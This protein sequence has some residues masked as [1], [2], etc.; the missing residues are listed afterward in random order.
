MAVNAG[1]WCFCECVTEL[2]K[3]FT[4]FINPNTFN[5]ITVDKNCGTYALT[6]PINNEI[7]STD[8]F[9]SSDYP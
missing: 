6:S 3:A 8:F 4:I 5:D 9:S 2:D 7:K 1:G